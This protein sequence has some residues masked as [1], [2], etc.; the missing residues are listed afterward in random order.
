MEKVINV[1][2][3][4]RHEMTVMQAN[5]LAA[6]IETEI[7]PDAELG[8][9]NQVSETVKTADE[10]VAKLTDETIIAAVLP[11][12]LLS[13]LFAKKPEGVMVVVP[14]SKRIKKDDGTFEFE[15]DGWEVVENVVYK[16]H[17]I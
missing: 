1:L 9:I 8:K 13:D 15:H 17:T 11:V 7:D 10:I 3:F 6:V 12:Q 4:S 2:W 14:R 5:G 16:S